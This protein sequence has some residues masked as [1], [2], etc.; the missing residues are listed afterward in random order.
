MKYFFEFEF[1]KIAKYFKTKRLAKSIT[2]L[3]FMLVFLLIFIGIYQ[4]FVSGFNYIDYNLERELRMPIT[5]FFYEIFLLVLSGII[6]F[7]CMVSG[8]FSLFRGEHDDW[9]I[10]SP[11][12]KLFPKFI[13][14]KS[15]LRSV[16]PF[17]I[18]F[19]PAV[20]AFYK[21]YNLSIFS[22]FFIFISFIVIL[23]LLNALVLSSII[24]ISSFYYLIS[25]IITGLKFSFKGVIL[26]MM[27][28]ASLTVSVIWRVSMDTDLVKLFRAD[29]AK[30]LADISSVSSHFYFLPTHSF[31]L[32]IVNWQNN[33]P[34][35]AMVNFSIILFLAAISI[36]VLWCT[37]SYFYPLWQK[38]REG[39]YRDSKRAE[40]YF[41]SGIT[42][43]FKGGRVMALFKKEALVLLRNPKGML[44]F[45]FLLFI[46]LMQIG[47]NVI[48]SS[49]IQKYQ[50]DMSQKM[51]ILQ[52]LQFIV[53][54]YFICSFT[55]RFVFPAFS[56]E[57]KM[58]WILA[59]APL[60]F[61]RIYFGKYLFYSLFFVV[62]G[63]LMGYINVRILNL[64]F[65]YAAYSMM[66]TIAAVM[67]IVILGLS[68]GAVFPN[69]ETDDPEVI[70]T[71]MPGLF[72]TALSLIYGALG[73]M[74]LYFTIIHGNIL[75][76]L[77]FTGLT[78]VLIVMILR[79]TV[80]LSGKRDL[81]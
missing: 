78:L 70:S 1:G 2:G 28:L 73:A 45:V 68:L 44:W 29:E 65:A 6:I 62:V 16:W 81:L 59:S 10:S 79:K 21:V 35:E 12:Y 72:F 34:A 75:N 61:K 49:N 4:F 8:L 56:I 46:W 24:L 52:S 58:A 18:A 40:S 47:T 57:K 39:S 80:S 15:L 69:F 14:V 22:L 53:A 31:A 41:T 74:A 7:S 27:V 9:I 64:P 54:V 77:F 60:S 66:L 71:S 20:L 19:L 26:I 23:I 48:L 50:T 32:E 51:A 13:F 25:K 42:F 30:N 37:S 63:V 17:F 67:F 55:L 76:V 38:L 33:R 11:A 5:L 36:F 43:Y 3:L